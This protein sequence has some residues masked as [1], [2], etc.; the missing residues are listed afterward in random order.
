MAI[1]PHN[2]DTAVRSHHGTNMLSGIRWGTAACAGLVGG[3]VFLMMEMLLIWIAMGQSPWG[4]PRMMAAMVMGKSVLP[5]PATFSAPIMMVAMAIHI[6][7]SVVYGVLLCA[8]VHRMS[9]GAALATGALFGLVAVYLVNF[10]VVAPMMFPWFTEAQN[11]VSV[12]S[13]VVF[14]VVIAAVYTSARDRRA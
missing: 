8:I 2:I 9:K 13:H 14:G 4:P 7:M 5:P 11:W 12:L 3:V 1:Q 6:M 10:H